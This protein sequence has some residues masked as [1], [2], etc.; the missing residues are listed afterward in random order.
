MLGHVVGRRFGAEQRHGAPQ[1][2]QRLPPGARDVG[3]C[4]LRDVGVALQ[5][6]GRTVGLHDH[7]AHRVCDHVVQFPGDPGALGG[8]RVLGAS[9][10]VIVGDNEAS[11]D[12]FVVGATGAE[13]FRGDPGQ[14][15][16]KHRVQSGCQQ[17][18]LQQPDR[19]YGVDDQ[20][21]RVDRCGAAVYVGDER[22]EAT[23][24]ASRP[25][26]SASRS[27]ME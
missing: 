16:H 14:R 9:I 3:Q 15:E 26:C 17:F 5:G 25:G 21:H 27:P 6:V 10:P 23:A 18:L 11:R 1:F 8:H 7:H 24:S 19:Q 12:L 13:E 20:A 2:R 4:L 22:V